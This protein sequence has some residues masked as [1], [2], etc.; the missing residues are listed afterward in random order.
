MIKY[1]ADLRNGKITYKN[2]TYYS[3]LSSNSWF[4][5]QG[6]ELGFVSWSSISGDLGSLPTEKSFADS[7]RTVASYS[8]SIGGLESFNGFM[9]EAR[10]QERYNWRV[11]YTAG[12]VNDYIREGFV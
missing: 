9:S 2:N 5:P 3:S 10:K 1:G 7:T 11:E 8:A 12:A 6:S 4:K